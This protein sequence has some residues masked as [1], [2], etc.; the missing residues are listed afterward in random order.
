[1]EEK[2]I[3]F[4]TDYFHKIDVAAITITADELSIGDRIHLKGHTTD[5]EQVVGSIQM[6]HASVQKAKKGDDVGIKIKDRVR[7]YDKV[8]K[9]VA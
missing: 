7:Q 8:Y 4:V 1:M 5:F 9:I 6:E 3:G 2:E